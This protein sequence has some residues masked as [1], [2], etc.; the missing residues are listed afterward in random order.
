MIIDEL[1]NRVRFDKILLWKTMVLLL[2]MYVGSIAGAPSFVNVPGA[3]FTMGR[4]G[5]VAAGARIM[6]DPNLT[7]TDGK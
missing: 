4:K 2:A 1:L 7:L 5:A 3:T 6:D